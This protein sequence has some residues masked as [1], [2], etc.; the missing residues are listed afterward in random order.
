MQSR[1]ESVWGLGRV[2]FPR[3]GRR[4]QAWPVGSQQV[5]GRCDLA[6]GSCFLGCL[7]CLVA[8]YS[9]DVASG[10]SLISCPP[11]LDTLSPFIL[12]WM[13]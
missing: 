1:K 6:P 7:K 8:A 10:T 13:R 5:P 9:K 3:G 2:E 11:K 4:L 12:T